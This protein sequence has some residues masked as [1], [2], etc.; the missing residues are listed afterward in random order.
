MNIELAEMAQFV[1]DNAFKGARGDSQVALSGAV[2]ALAGCISIVQLN[3][4]SFG[5]DEYKWTEKIIAD[6]GDLKSIYENL[7]T[8]ANSKIEILEIEVKHKAVL[9]KEVN[10]LLLSIRSKQNPSDTEIENSAIQFQRLIWRYRGEIWKKDISDRPN[11]ILSPGII[12]KKVLGYEFY[13]SPELGINYGQ[14]GIS[15]IAGIIDQKNKLVLISEKF[16][17]QTQ[18]FTSAHELGHALLHNQVVMHRDRPIDGIET[19]SKRSP[20]ELQ[21]DKFASYFLMPKKQVIAIFQEYF[22][23]EKFIIDGNSAFNLTQDRE[24]TLRADCRDLRGLSR[25]LAKTESFYSR[26]FKSIA[27]LFN[28][29]V[30]TMAIRL[31]E[32]DLVEF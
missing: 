9:Y 32:L 4:L 21:A 18:N 19:K 28:V 20:Q 1:F 25:K 16:S 11:E 6:V 3:L 12:F 15:E 2:S 24:S 17:E 30:E 23:T 5:H 13:K 22:L 26:P 14:K 10:Q 31:E 29:S 27:E 7:N 8:I